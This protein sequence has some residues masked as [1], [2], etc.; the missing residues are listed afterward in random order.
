MGRPNSLNP[1][2]AR[3]GRRLPAVLAAAAGLVLSMVAPSQA[4]QF[5]RINDVNVNCSDALQCDLYI[6]NPRV[7]LYSAGLR[8]AAAPDAPIRLFFVLSEALAAGSELTL[9]IDG[10][11]VVTIPVSDLAYRAAISEYSYGDPATAEAFVAGIKAGRTLT[12]SYRTRSGQSLAQYALAGTGEGIAF[13]D[14]VQGRSG[15]PDALAA[16]GGRPGPGDGEGTTVPVET[17]EGLPA[18]LR[19]LLA[20]PGGAC[21]TTD[22]AP[23]PQAGGFSAERGNGTSLYG[24]RCGE[25][26]ASNVPFALFAVEGD[27]VRRLP[28][29]F[30]TA[31]GPVAGDIGSNIA[32]DSERRE[33]TAVFK[34]RGLGDCGTVDRWRLSG[35]GG[36]LRFVLVEARAQE[37]CGGAATS[38]PGNWPLLWPVEQK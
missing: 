33:L 6:T 16:I 26:G 27:T 3:D 2:G 31:E 7:T 35:N 4:S 13:M 34:G 36:E 21:L 11:A 20:A 12:I 15:G 9:S 23:P 10:R 25:A 5:K 38:D 19:A 37:S 29:A 28:L 30:M 22:G 14:Q 8:R 1:S 32:F 24:L 17:L 18:G